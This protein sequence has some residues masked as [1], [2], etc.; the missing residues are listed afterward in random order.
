MSQPVRAAIT[1]VS[2]YHPEK[3][4]TNRE[5]E[6]IVDTNDEWIQTRTGIKER[7]F[8]EKGVGS[9]DLAVLAIQKL[10]KQTE[11]RPEEIDLIIVGTVTPDMMFPSTAC[12][13]ARKLGAKNAWGFDLSAACSGFL[14][15]LSTG[16]QFIRSG[17]H[18]KVLVV[19]V[20]V[21]SSILN[22]KDRNTCVLFGD[23]AGAVLLEPV[24]ID[25]QLGI[26]DSVEHVDGVGGD[27]LY[28]PAGGSLNP[29]TIETVEKNMHYVHQEGKSVYKYAVSGMANVAVEIL[30]RNKINPK[31]V[32]L[33]V[34]H[35]ANLRII[36]STQKK[37]NLPDEKVMVTIHKYANTT[38]ATIPTCLAVAQEEG[39]LKKGDLV[40]AVAFGAGFTWGAS[41]IR[42]AY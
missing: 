17:K 19:G 1:G 12:L 31:E 39:R 2:M 21:M 10:L 41:L 32:D 40:L 3:V 23:G 9:S 30:E 5:L 38:A 7:R 20:D 33:F 26:L 27:F 25:R 14:F 36:E 11:T 42:W 13:I 37:L 18:K 22:F 29:P 16:E 15:A 24:L 8:V 4:V 35:Q 34:A 28:M 6:A